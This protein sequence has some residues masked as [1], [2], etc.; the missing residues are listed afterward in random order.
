MT[1]AAPRS[2][3]LA[4]TPR[5]GSYIWVTNVTGLLAGDDHCQW[6]AFCKSH[7]RYEKRV[8]DGGEALSRWMAEHDRLVVARE[9]ELREA[10]W[11]VT[12]EDQN[13]LTVRGVAT[14]AGKP[15][16][17]AIKGK[18]ILISD[19][20]GGARKHKY[21][22]QVR[23]YLALYPL[24]YSEAC[25]GKRLVGEL[26]YPDGRLEVTLEP[27]DAARIFLQ[28]KATGSGPEPETTPSAREC[29]YC[30]VGPCPDRVALDVEAASSGGRF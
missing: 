13:A 14:V 19:A 16:L 2:L 29:R 10:G 30:D 28:L 1:K 7:Y 15:D 8:D 9:A 22:W 6:A 3:V 25:R 11:R 26:V 4:L 12:V 17:V 21:T 27:G 20:K 23:T 18:T 24:Q 5:R